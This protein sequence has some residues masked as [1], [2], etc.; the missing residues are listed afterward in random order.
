[1][2]FFDFDWVGDIFGSATQAVGT[3][4]GAGIGFMVGG[5]WG[6]AIGGGMGY[7]MFG[8][9]TQFKDMPSPPSPS[10]YYVYKEDGTL[11]YSTTWNASTNSYTTQYGPKTPEEKA[12][13]GKRTALRDELLNRLSGTST[14]TEA[15]E[16]AKYYSDYAKAFSGQMHSTLDEQFKKSEE[17][18]VE[19]LQKQ[20]LFGSKAYADI[21]SEF[22]K[23]K[24][25]AS[26][27]I[28]RQG[29]LAASTLRQQDITTDI[30]LLDMLD[31][32]KTTAETLNLQKASA[33]ER[34]ASLGN[35]ALYGGYSAQMSLAQNQYLA[36]Q[37]RRSQILDTATGLA[38][39]Y[40]L[41]KFG[42]G[43]GSLLSSTSKLPFGA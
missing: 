34:G 39:L 14:S 1:M 15:K 40:G 31:R 26:E 2:G 6:A 12:E 29:T 17:A 19:S 28:E 27:D 33:S 24:A 8:G 5:P 35:A 4:A 43:G 11:E 13:E 42:G 10:N 9:G 22:T 20:G 18:R 16:R 30:G 36:D 21:T 3:A 38:Y 41:G 7:S 23:E 32:G 37:A 25:R